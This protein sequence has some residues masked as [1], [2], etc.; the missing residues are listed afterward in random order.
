MIRS[1]AFG[2]LVIILGGLLSGGCSEDSVTVLADA[3]PIVADQQYYPTEPETFWIYRFDTT[4]VT[5]PTVKDAYR[6]KSS[7]R[8]SMKLD[9][10]YYAVQVNETA[11]GI[12]VT[13]D[14]IFIRK[15]AKGVYASS[16]LLQ[17]ATGI[18]GLPGLTID[19]PKEVMLMPY[20]PETG[21]TW[22][23]FK[24]EYTIGFITFYF[25]AKA[26]YITTEPVTTDYMT[27]RN[28]VRIRILV[29]ALLP[30][31]ED[32]TNI[33]NPLRINETGSFWFTR[34]GGLVMADGKQIVFD[35]LDGRFP[36]ILNPPQRRIHQEVTAMDIVQPDDMC[37]YR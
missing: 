19:I 24:I 31:P 16:F 28:C 35:L 22:D 1:G 17:G 18:P 23:I 21:G 20:P 9:S 36:N 2:L 10:L 4:G 30:N 7:I 8:S 13:M 37:I 14:T 26:S 12:D 29:E 5:G 3:E 34:P 11:Q 25:R 15:D 32:P 33:L 6:K 27:F